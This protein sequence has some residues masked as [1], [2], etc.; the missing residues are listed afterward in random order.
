MGCA[1]SSPTAEKEA[2]PTSG[3]VVLWATCPTSNYLALP[4]DVATI[5]GC[6]REDLVDLRHPQ[7]GIAFLAR[8]AQTLRVVGMY[9]SAELVGR[10]LGANQ[11]VGTAQVTPTKGTFNVPDAVE[12]LFQ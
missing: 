9:R 10:A 4:R 11:I 2:T 8:P 1:E 3:W 12:V 6:T 5:F 7:R